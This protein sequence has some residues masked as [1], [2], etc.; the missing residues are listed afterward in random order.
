[1]ATVLTEDANKE[2]LRLINSYIV[3]KHQKQLLFHNPGI[4]ESAAATQA[5][6][7]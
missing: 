2:V 6:R 4:S 7:S 5:Y 3:D 1:M